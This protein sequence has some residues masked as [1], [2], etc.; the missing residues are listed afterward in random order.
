MAGKGK[1]L[2]VR[3]LLAGC[4]SSNYPGESLADGE[5]MQTAAVHGDPDSDSA[6]SGR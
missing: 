6:D 4:Q 1:R 2:G 3:P 5:V